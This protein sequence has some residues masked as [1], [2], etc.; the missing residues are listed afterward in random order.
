MYIT[1]QLALIGMFCGLETKNY[2]ANQDDRMLMYNIPSFDYLAIEGTPKIWLL[3]QT[4]NKTTVYLARNVNHD[5]HTL[6]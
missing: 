5:D 6:G 3:P 2:F 1:C 4:E